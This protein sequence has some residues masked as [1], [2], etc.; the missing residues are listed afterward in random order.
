MS[1][2][3]AGFLVVC[4]LMSS[5]AIA[6]A[7]IVVDA[8]LPPIEQTQGDLRDEIR[9][10]LTARRELNL[11]RFRAYVAA[12]VYPLNT[13]QPGALNVFIDAEGHICAAATIMTMDGL[14]ELVRAQAASNDFVRLGEVREGPLYARNLGSGFTQEELAMIQEPFMGPD[15]MVEPPIE[16]LREEEK[17]RLRARYR[18]ILSQLEQGRAA[19]LEIAIDRLLAQRLRG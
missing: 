1:S 14:G 19:S 6:Q 5:A 13:F 3:G 7:Q 17:I 4:W 15:E 2:R 12:E 8:P 11:A 16:Q 9:R 10:E 18:V